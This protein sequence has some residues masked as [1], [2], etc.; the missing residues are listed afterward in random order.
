MMLTPVMPVMQLM[1]VMNTKMML[2]IKL[3]DGD[4]VQVSTHRASQMARS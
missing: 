1:L 3:A 2:M 4:H